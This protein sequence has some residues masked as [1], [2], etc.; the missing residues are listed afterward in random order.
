MAETFAPESHSWKL[1]RDFTITPVYQVVEDEYE[2]GNTTSTAIS[3]IPRRRFSARY[4]SAGTKAGYHYMTAFFLRNVGPAARF[5]FVAPEE[6]S[7]PDKGPTL[8]SAAGGT[9]GSR[10]IYVKFAWQNTAGITVASAATSL[11]VP[12]NE[13]MTVT[14]PFYPPSVTQAVIYATQ[15]SAGSEQEQTTL[16]APTRTW[17][18]PDAALLTGNPVPPTT[19]TAPETWSNA[20]LVD[21]SLNFRRGVGLSY[22]ATLEIDER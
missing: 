1:Q 8:T 12:A 6:V 7:D 2:L 9:Q 11:A 13:L 3:R 4:V 5:T 14:V 18:Q 20:K 15:G 17:L 22:E 21:G 10:T 16:T 19:N